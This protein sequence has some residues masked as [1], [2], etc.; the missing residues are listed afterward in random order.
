VALVWLTL[1]ACGSGSAGLR[2]GPDGGVGA[3]PLEP[4]GTYTGPG[5]DTPAAHVAAMATLLSAEQPLRRYASGTDR[6]G[7]W[8][9]HV[10]VGIHDPIYNPVTFRLPITAAQIADK[11]NR[12]VTPYF[13]TLSHGVYQ[14]RFIA[15]GEVSIGVN[16]TNTDCVSAARRRS[17]PDIAGLLVVA[18]AEHGATEPGGWGTPGT[19]CPGSGP[20]SAGVTGRAAYVGASDFH[21][22][23]GPVPAIDLEEH[24]IGHM[25]GLPHSGGGDGHTSALDVMSNSAAPRDVDPTR[26]NGP[27]TLGIDRVQLGWLPLTDVAVV[28]S[29]GGTYTLAPST[30]T[31]GTRLLVVPLG[32]LRLLSVE[33]LPNTGFD[34]HLPHAGVVVHDIDQSSDA[35]GVRAPRLCVNEYRHQLP[36]SATAPYTQL[37]TVGASYQG[38][39]WKLTVVRAEQERWTIAMTKETP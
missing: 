36:L 38:E 16:Q 23:W 37:L 15:A 24:E 33:V 8:V 11:L 27:D 18:D 39:G 17:A 13:V 25:L 4:T 7:V 5:A 28:G 32:S 26:R 19:P 14:P 3:G 10:A 2:A 29:R 9:C 31:A 12:Y 30:A 22:D 20:C 35:C 34:S 1:A 21:P 6:L